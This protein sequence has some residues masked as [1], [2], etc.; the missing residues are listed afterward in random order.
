MAAIRAA[1]RGP[2]VKIGLTVDVNQIAANHVL[3]IFADVDHMWT[4]YD[5]IEVRDRRGSDALRL[6]PGND[7]AYRPDDVSGN[8]LVL[9]GDRG[10]TNEEDQSQRDSSY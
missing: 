4:E 10:Q 5:L 7:S 2:S 8:L 1:L 6:H 9:V 3:A